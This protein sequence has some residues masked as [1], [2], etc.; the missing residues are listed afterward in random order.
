M[1]FG[2]IKIRFCFSY[3]QS[4]KSRKP[5]RFAEKSFDVIRTQCSLLRLARTKTNLF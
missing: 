2:R 3:S 4:C 1:L 5:E